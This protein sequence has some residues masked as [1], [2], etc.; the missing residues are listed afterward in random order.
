M[1]DLVGRGAKLEVGVLC[2]S[3]LGGRW[4]VAILIAAVVG[5]A[6]ADRVG[7]FRARM[8]RLFVVAVAGSSRG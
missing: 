6:R 5:M 7:C 4:R 8:W 3:G 1:L 2:W